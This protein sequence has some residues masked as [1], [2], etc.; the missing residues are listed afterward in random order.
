[1]SLKRM[2]QVLCALALLCGCVFS[3]TTTGT[4]TGM[5]TDSSNA[6]VPGVQI[7]IKNLTTGAIRTTVSGPEGIFGFNSLE[8]ARY[9]LTAKATGFK[10]YTQT[11]IAVTP[12]SIRD[13]GKLALS[14]GAL[15]EEVSVVAVA[16]PVQ[17]TSSENSK[18][19]NEDQRSE[20][21]T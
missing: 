21:H 4:L 20:E 3:Q 12:S 14:L 19:V 5:V 2:A 13:L 18:L 9:N 10:S 6:A 7:E 15:T 1:M 11:D 17:T 8:P 16:T